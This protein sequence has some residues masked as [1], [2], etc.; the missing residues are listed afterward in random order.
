MKPEEEN[1]ERL[2]KL[3]ALALRLIL[4]EISTLKE[5]LN[6]IKADDEND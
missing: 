2:L 3:H 4:K 6:F 5:I 1:Y